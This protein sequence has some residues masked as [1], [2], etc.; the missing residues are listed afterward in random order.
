MFYS[1]VRKGSAAFC[2]VKASCCEFGITF[3]LLSGETRVTR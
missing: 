2:Y 3:V 1:T